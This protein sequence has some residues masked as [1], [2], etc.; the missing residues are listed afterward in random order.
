MESTFAGKT[1][2]VTG[3]NRGLGQALVE[4]AL[5]RGAERVYAGT[6]QPF[7]HPDERVVPVAFS[8]RPDRPRPRFRGPSGQSRITRRSDQQRRRRALRRLERSRRA[9]TAPRGQPVRTVEPDAGV[10]A[11]VDERARSDRQRPVDG[12]CRGRPDHPVL[13]D[14]EGGVVVAVPVAEGA[15]GAARRQRPCRAGRPNE[16]R[17]V[18][19]ASNREGI[20]RVSRASDH[21]RCAGRRR[22]HL[23]GSDVSALGGELARRARSR[24]WSARTRR[25]SRPR[26]HRVNEEDSTPWRR[27]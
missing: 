24:S 3:A 23:P 19:R 26:A 22:R 15:V 7:S 6:R 20:D 4:E 1:V 9:R 16:H 18:A 13:F 11:A 5:S 10:P 2:L 8:Y 21:R 17:D 27:R 14:L 12:G 25:W